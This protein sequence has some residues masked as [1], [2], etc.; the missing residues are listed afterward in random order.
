MNREKMHLILHTVAR[1]FLASI[2]LMYAV[3]KILGTQFSSSPSVWDKSVG[4]LSGFELTWFYFGYSFWYGVFIAT[5]QI[6]AASLL[7]FR[8]TT[9]LGITLYLSIMVNILVI[10][11]T[12]DIRGAKQRK[13]AKQNRKAK[14][15]K[16][17]K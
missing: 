12:Y 17:P 10:D 13:E 2:I 15:N 7:F 1:Y 8:R 11:F 16:K 4:E 3:A 6:L 5:S 14:Q 9:R